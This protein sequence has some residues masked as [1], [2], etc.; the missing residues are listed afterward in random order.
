MDNFTIANKKNAMRLLSIVSIIFL[1]VG[2][3]IAQNPLIIFSEHS[4]A[5]LTAE[6]IMNGDSIKAKLDL[7][8]SAGVPNGANVYVNGNNISYTLKG[9]N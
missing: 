6:Q 9:G 2:F 5:P 3:V 7:L 1:L 8:K 4:Q